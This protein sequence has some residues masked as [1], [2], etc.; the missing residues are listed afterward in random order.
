MLTK[1]LAAE[2]GAVVREMGYV[3]AVKA[4]DVAHLLDRKLTNTFICR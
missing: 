2:F 4:N 3:Y 1:H